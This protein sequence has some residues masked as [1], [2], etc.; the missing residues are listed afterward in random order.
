VRCKSKNRRF[1]GRPVKVFL[2]KKAPW[3]W[4]MV[5]GNLYHLILWVSGQTR[6]LLRDGD[7]RMHDNYVLIAV[8]KSC[9]LTLMLIKYKKTCRC[10][11][12]AV[13]FLSLVLI[14]LLIICKKS[15][16][17][18]ETIL[19]LLIFRR[20]FFTLDQLTFPIA[21]VWSLKSPSWWN[22]TNSWIPYRGKQWEFCYWLH[23]CSFL[24][25]LLLSNINF[26]MTAILTLRR[27][28]EKIIVTGDWM[29][30]C[31]C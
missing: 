8:W 25:F 14:A 11:Q 7:S 22:P 26:C 31:F 30:S 16:S 9:H 20:Q 1:S 18:S 29:L 17:V 28:P 5:R 27:L 13:T 2:G 24:C 23:A 10:S 12:V 6:S 4:K 15:Y 21:A 19:A 3:L